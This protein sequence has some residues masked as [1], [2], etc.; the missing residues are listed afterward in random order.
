MINAVIIFTYLSIFWGLIHSHRLGVY[1]NLYKEEIDK[2]QRF[3]N[4]SFCHWLIA[5]FRGVL[6][7]STVVTFLSCYFRASQSL[8]CVWRLSICVLIG[9]EGLWK[10]LA[11]PRL[12]HIT[13]AKPTR[14]PCMGLWVWWDCPLRFPPALEMTTLPGQIP[15]LLA[16]QSW[17]VVLAT[18]G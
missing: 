1:R 16:S 10:K 15:S 11:F 6:C 17:W 4:F 7:V 13:Q 8:S 14:S 18:K 3:K 9:Q 5:V 2:D 12:R